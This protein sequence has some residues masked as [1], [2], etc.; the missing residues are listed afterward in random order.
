MA[1]QRPQFYSVFVDP[2]SLLLSAWPLCRDR[3]RNRRGTTH[4]TQL[5]RT[6]SRRT[7]A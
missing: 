5:G 4:R 1:L 7:T 3:L 2:C 6:Q